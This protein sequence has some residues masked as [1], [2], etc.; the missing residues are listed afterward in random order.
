MK[1]MILLFVVLFLVSGCR[2]DH[3]GTVVD[4]R[5]EPGCHALYVRPDVV[6]NGVKRFCVTKDA[7]NGYNTGD[8]FTWTR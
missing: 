7:Y 6:T 1:R 3:H 4:K 2:T 8:S 5:N